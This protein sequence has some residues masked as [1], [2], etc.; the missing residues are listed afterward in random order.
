SGAS[1]ITEQLVRNVLL[2]PEEQQTQTMQ[3]KLGEAVLA[4]RV[5]QRYSKDEILQRYLNE[6]NYGNLAYGVAAASETYFGKPV[7]QLDLAEAALIAGLPQGPAFY[8]PYQHP[9][10]AKQRQRDVLAL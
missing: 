1:T 10:A 3:R 9:D 6:I 7:Q 8:D 5:T 2:T 4:L